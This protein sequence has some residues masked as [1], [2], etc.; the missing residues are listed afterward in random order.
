[1][2]TAGVRRKRKNKEIIE[3]GSLY[4]N[5][6]SSNDYKSAAN[7]VYW[8]TLKV[9]GSEGII[10]ALEDANSFIKTKDIRRGI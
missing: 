8:A 1:M 6:I 3:S 10:D 5:F 2:G 9:S 4:S 7:V